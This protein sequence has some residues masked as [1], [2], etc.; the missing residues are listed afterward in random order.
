MKKSLTIVSYSVESVNTYY[1]QIKSLFLDAI[2][3]KKVYID[4]YGAIEEIDSDV[5][6]I[7]SYDMFERIR[8]YIREDVDLI[9]ANRTLSKKGLEKLME[10][11]EGTE[12]V[13]VDESP[14]MTVQIM[15]VIYQ[16]LGNRLNLKSYWE[17]DK[18]Q[19]KE[20]IVIILGQSD[21]VPKAAKRIINIGNSLLDFNT[22]I[23]IGMKFNI[24]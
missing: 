21:Y 23:D 14:E 3:I 5:V 12:V 1:A 17:L 6:L 13:I 20:K 22:I 8:K 7:P 18:E 10:I 4:S 16:L 9:F 15:S 19:I 11:P 24:L 2:D